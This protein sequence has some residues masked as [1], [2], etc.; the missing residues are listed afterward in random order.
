MI[1]SAYTHTIF[2]TASLDT[3]TAKHSSGVFSIDY[4]KSPLSEPIKH[5][6]MGKYKCS[7]YSC[8]SCCSE[9][10]NHLV[11]ESEPARFGLSVFTCN[12]RV[13]I[14][15]EW[16][17]FNKCK[18]RNCDGK[19]NAQCHQMFQDLISGLRANMTQS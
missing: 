17:N 2:S 10:T 1:C 18:E 6:T 13:N 12:C 8:S 19:I 3:S 14:T 5:D 16:W 11:Y 7:D 4:K 15:L 9:T